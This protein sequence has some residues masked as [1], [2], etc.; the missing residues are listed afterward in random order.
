MLSRRLSYGGALKERP[1]PGGYGTRATITSPNKVLICTNE[2]LSDGWIERDTHGAVLQAPGLDE[3]AELDQEL[4]VV[5]L[6]RGPDRER[7]CVHPLGDAIGR[8]QCSSECIGRVAIRYTQEHSL[9][10]RRPYDFVRTAQ[11]VLRAKSG[12][13]GTAFPSMGA[14]SPGC[15]RYP[16]PY[17]WTDFGLAFGFGLGLSFFCAGGLAGAAGSFLTTNVALPRSAP[18][19]PSALGPTP[20][21]TNQ[22]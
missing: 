9:H 12:N 18:Y 1:G 8:H 3:E 14:L 6:L 11:G 4:P 21:Q 10:R 20:G 22:R 5:E 15:G 13:F 19:F 2:R 16:Q 17:L 7:F